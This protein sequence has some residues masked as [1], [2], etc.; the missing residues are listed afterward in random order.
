[1]II[2]SDNKTIE[3]ALITLEERL[4]EHG[5][6]FHPQLVTESIDGSLSMSIEGHLNPAEKI[7]SVPRKLLIPAQD[8]HIKV[9][10]NQFVAEPDMDIITP[11]QAEIGQAMLDV[12]NATNKVN[13]HKKECPWIAFKDTPTLLQKLAKARTHNHNIAKK[14]SYINGEDD[15]LDDDE[16][17]VW[18]YLY[19]RVLGAKLGEEETKTQVIMP[20]VDFLNHNHKGCPY[21]FANDDNDEMAL[22]IKNLQPVI[23]SNECYVLYGT[24][25]TL[26]TYL[27]Y[28][29]P[30]TQAPYVRS[31]PLNIEVQGH[32]PLVIRSVPGV[33]RQKGTPDIVKDIAAFMPGMYRQK[34]EALNISHILIPISNAPHALRRILH[35]IIRSHVGKAATQEF[36]IDHVYKAEKEI[37][38]ANIAFYEALL[39]DVETE[40]APEDCKESIRHVAQTQ[41]TKVNKYL[42]APTF[43]KSIQENA[44]SNKNQDEDDP[45]EFDDEEDEDSAE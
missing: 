45:I 17:L 31:V 4:V 35:V 12:Y 44:A 26:D 19:S 22:T 20:V 37:I 13:M 25:D 3:K 15:A 38:E 24:Y 1:M 43:F 2:K 42:F 32:P 5:S 39:K 41:L 11:A 14:L 9:K 16:F 6:W 7:M 27:N 10:D 34:D 18:S 21:T 29:F 23:D 33:R 30:E 36:V 8:M 40:E 28:G